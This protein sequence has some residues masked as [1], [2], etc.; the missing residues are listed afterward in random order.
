M[1]FLKHL[2]PGDIVRLRNDRIDVIIPSNPHRHASWKI[3]GANSN[4]WSEDG[5]WAS[6]EHDM[7]EHDIVGLIVTAKQLKTIKDETTPIDIDAGYESFMNGKQ[8]FY[9]WLNK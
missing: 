7:S 6:S 1:E 4:Y 8:E 2:E 3:Q 9:K 5:R